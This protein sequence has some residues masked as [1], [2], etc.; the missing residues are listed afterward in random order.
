MLGGVSVCRESGQPFIHVYGEIGGLSVSA[1]DYG[2]LV[3]EF[4]PA[5]PDL[6]VAFS[7]TIPTF[8]CKYTID[9]SNPDVVEGWL[10][11][12]YQTL[13]IDWGYD[14]FKHDGQ[15]DVVN[16]YRKVKLYQPDKQS[17]QAYRSGLK[18]IREVITPQRFMLYCSGTANEGL[19]LIDGTRTGADVGADWMEIFP[20]YDCTRTQVFLNNI[21]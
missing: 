12:L 20:G 3:M 6:A 9:T 2:E 15:T 1:E 17:G 19:G 10:K 4:L 7:G 16:L 14:Y 21:A 18:A 5:K 11:P 13:A 8:N